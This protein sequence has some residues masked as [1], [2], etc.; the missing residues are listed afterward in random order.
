VARRKGPN[1]RTGK[2]T[3]AKPGKRPA[4]RRRDAH[5]GPPTLDRVLRVLEARAPQLLSPAAIAAALSQGKGASKAIRAVLREL[6]RESRVERIRGRYRALRTGATLEGRFTREDGARSGLVIDDGGGVWRVGRVEGVKPGDR[7]AIE[8]FGDP[9]KRRAD[10]LDV[11][12]GARDEWVGLFH[13][14]GKLAYATPY[15]DEGHWVVR[16]ARDHAG[17]AEEG[18][19]VR[20]EPVERRGR[21]RS[22]GEA[23]PW[24]R[25]VARLGRPGDP[26]ADVAAVVWRRRLSEAFPADVEAEARQV[27]VTPPDANAD[28]GRRDL[29][30]KSFF[31]IDPASAR[32][33]DDAV[34]VE[35]LEQGW[36]LFV[37]IAD[38]AAYV[39]AGSAIDREALARG[40]SVY[41][42]T[43]A[44]P[45]L[46]EALSSDACSLRP[47]ED[48]R[49]L[50]AELECGAGGRVRKSRFYAAWIR[51]RA[52]LAYTKAAEIMAGEGA[53]PLDADLRAF[54]A[55]AAKLTAQR[56]HDG[57]LDL[58][59]PS[60]HLVLGKDGRPID[61][62]PADR[63]AAHRAVEEAMLAANKAV[64]MHL[65]ERGYPAVFRNHDPPAPEDAEALSQKLAKFGL[66]EDGSPLSA[67]VI[68]RAI[69]D[70]SA[71][72]ARVV[73][74]LVLRAMRQARYG[75]ECRGHFALAFESYL[76]FTSPIRRYPDLVVHRVLRALMAGDG[77]PHDAQRVGRMAA[78][79]SYRE[80]L[81]ERA[82]REVRMLAKC[83]F[84][85][86]YVGEEL[87][88]TVT[89]V[90]RHGL[91][92][93]FDRW[94]A[95]GLIHVSRL[96]E[97][98][99]LAEDRLSLVAEGSRRRYSLGDRM[100]VRIAEVD[101]VQGQVDLEIV[102]LLESARERR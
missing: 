50:V 77:P 64:A 93:T 13:R 82:E 48:R 8:P 53:H 95:D 37:A 85:S 31:T 57:A 5:K 20:L 91:Y 4:R 63:T 19:V 102:R 44:I 100:L 34:C 58:D 43:R 78:R 18:E 7:V 21:G 71:A 23:E 54:G 16:V 74:P 1:K 99:F 101:I 52:R 62:V 38:V 80:R 60:A 92:F 68:S 88:G 90:A 15:R 61:I 72:V 65:L 97:F 81:A 22:G 10:V 86:A 70:A 42:P 33:H 45:M 39:E 67:A 29:R 51:S 94:P 27:A 66:M 55:L 17:D 24:G 3:R 98:V 84:L 87:E 47:D 32:D 2:G 83:A 28:Q 46:P 96:P 9:T 49:V 36:R 73:N 40:N 35:T 69:A 75:A 25:V 6:E 14:R 41:F 12:D 89:G 76:H 30:E 79:S 59:L 26:D 56:L 11:V